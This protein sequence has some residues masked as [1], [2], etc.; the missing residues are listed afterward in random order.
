[1]Y[2]PAHLD[3]FLRLLISHLSTV[4][5]QGE[6]IGRLPVSDLPM[7]ALCKALEMEPQDSPAM[8]QLALRRDFEALFVLQMS[9]AREWVDRLGQLDPFVERETDEF[10]AA[11]FAIEKLLDERASRDRDYRLENR[12]AQP[13]NDNV[14]RAD[15]LANVDVEAMMLAIFELLARLEEQYDLMEELLEEKRVVNG[16]PFAAPAKSAPG[17]RIIP[18]FAARRAK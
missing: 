13:G 15:L 11:T 4:V 16:S 3:S 8:D 7:Q 18:L 2:Q 14:L 5:D 10:L 1:M 9:Q 17:A 6:Q 12:M